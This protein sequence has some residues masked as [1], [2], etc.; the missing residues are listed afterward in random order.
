MYNG[1]TNRET[2]L[3]VLHHRDDFDEIAREDYTRDSDPYDFAETLQETAP[4]IMDA[5]DGVSWNSD[6]FW[7]AFNV[8]NWVEIAREILNELDE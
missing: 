2:W 4:E 1:W 7:D 5:P 3:M 8:V 6:I